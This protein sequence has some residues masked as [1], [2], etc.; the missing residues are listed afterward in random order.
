MASVA[1]LGFSIIS[2]YSGRGM[3]E[4]RRDIASTRAF[5]SLLN[6]D[7]RNHTRLLSGVPTRWKAIGVAV[8]GLAPALV[9]L[10]AQLLSTAA[11]LTT[12]GAAAG[13]AAGVWGLA[14]KGALGRIN[15]T[16][17]GVMAL[18]KNLAKQ[19]AILDNMTPGT[20]HYNKQLKA[21]AKAQ[22]QYNHALA[23]AEI[24]RA[25]V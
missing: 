14:L 8:A 15:E 23:D 16:S 1:T 20:A 22:D 9:P 3:A 12:M 19:K 13:G 17:T 21:V 10:T 6:E 18:G 24:G 5:L 25:H 4:A 2:R 7:I 11:A